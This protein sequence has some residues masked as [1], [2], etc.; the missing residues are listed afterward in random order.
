MQNNTYVTFV[1]WAQMMLFWSSLE[2]TDVSDLHVC[3]SVCRHERKR[4]QEALNESRAAAVKKDL[5]NV[6]IR[7]LS[8]RSFICDPGRF[9]VHSAERMWTHGAQTSSECGLKGSDHHPVWVRSH[10]Y[11][12][13][14][15][16][17]RITKPHVDTR[18]V[19]DLRLTERD[20]PNL[21]FGSELSSIK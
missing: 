8:R 14:S 17:D 18:C 3:V 5:R 4:S 10:L 13:L 19:R 21:F 11:S 2:F 1:S 12:E 20:D 15:T 7:G 9:G 6:L 16:C